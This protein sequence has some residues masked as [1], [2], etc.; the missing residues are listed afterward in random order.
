MSESTG[1]S[2]T[3]YILLLKKKGQ[4]FPGGP[5]VKSLPFNAEDT[6]SISGGG[7]KLPYAMGQLDIHCNC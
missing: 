2:H 4:D 7:T 5:V 3:A 6:C 1:F